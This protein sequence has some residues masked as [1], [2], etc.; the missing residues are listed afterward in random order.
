M[1]HKMKLTMSSFDA[2][3]SGKKNIEVRLYDKKRQSINVGDEIE[4]TKEP[5]REEKLKVQ[6][7]GLLRYRTFSDL[8]TDYS[9]KHFGASSKKNLLNSIYSHYTKEE[10]AKYGVVGIRIKKSN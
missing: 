7:V 5:K 4:F 6:V 2:I 3:E 9:S 8:V 1:L 10:E